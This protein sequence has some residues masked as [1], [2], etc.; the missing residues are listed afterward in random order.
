[1]QLGITKV[2]CRCTEVALSDYFITAH[3]NS[4][5]MCLNLP[6]LNV[7]DRLEVCW[8]YAFWQRFPIDEETGFGA[9]YSAITLGEASPFV[10]VGN[11]PGSLV[12]PAE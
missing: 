8:R 11:L 10:R 2:S 12:L 6:G 3:S 5:L 7:T 4:D 9:F 1:M